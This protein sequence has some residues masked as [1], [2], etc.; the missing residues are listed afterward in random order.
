MPYR[1]SV[2]TKVLKES[3]Q[4][5][6]LVAMVACISPTGP[7]MQETINTLR[8][9]NKA[10]ALVTKP[11][12]AL[13]LA[14]QGTPAA[15]KR[16]LADFIPPTPGINNT[17]H[18]PTPSKAARK[19]DTKRQLN[20]T[21]GTPGK[22]AR[23]EN[24][25][26]TPRSFPQRAT[27]TATKTTVV[28]RSSPLSPTFSNLSGVS[29]IEHP[30]EC[31]ESSVA[32]TIEGDN[33][34]ED[35]RLDSKTFSIQDISSAISPFMRQMNEKFTVLTQEVRR[36]Q[37]K[38][39]ES[40]KRNCRPRMTSSPVRSTRKSPRNRGFI[41]ESQTANS[42]P[43]LSTGQQEV[44][45]SSTESLISGAVSRVPLQQVTNTRLQAVRDSTSPVL[46]GKLPR[47]S[48][49]A[50]AA[51]ALPR[52]PTI[53]EMERCLG[54]GPESP[55]DIFSVASDQSAAAP[56]PARQSR[57]SARRTS[58]GGSELETT[59]QFIRESAASRR[60]SGRP[61]RAATLGLY[62]GSP[63]K[64]NLQNNSEKVCIFIS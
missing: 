24:T 30:E 21:I 37:S 22:R 45:P 64:E 36:L 39:A 63:N 5:T 51:S 26:T 1:D 44:S 48:P 55:G 54:I 60:L 33:P 52:S 17:I 28:D 7:D 32:T 20:L 34:E 57:R 42:S 43:A 2:L 49:N 3:L 8:F 38:K 10:K 12:P 29:M 14:S 59:L 11:V 23:G 50:A 9:A 16:Q 62:Y 56:R 25:F 46:G 4:T 18:T 40:P 27:S 13:L 31:E 6:A 35:T 58:M 47:N 41:Q 61:T 15:R 53:E 19:N